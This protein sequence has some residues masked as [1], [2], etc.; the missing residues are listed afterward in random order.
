MLGPEENV[1]IYQYPDGEKLLG[2]VLKLRA[3]EVAGNRVLIHRF[4]A[5]RESPEPGD[6]KKTELGAPKK[7]S[8]ENNQ[9]KPPAMAHS[10]T[11]ATRET[12]TLLH[13]TEP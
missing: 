10:P 2:R 8:S 6:P 12:R 13:T 1:K 5:E 11:P 4:L 9:P 3:E 7:N